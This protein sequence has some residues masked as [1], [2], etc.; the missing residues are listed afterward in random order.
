VI[1]QID[2]KKFAEATVHYTAAELDANRR[3]VS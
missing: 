1:I 3:G 2:G